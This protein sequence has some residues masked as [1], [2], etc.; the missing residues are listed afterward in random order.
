[1]NAAPA[2]VYGPWLEYLPPTLFGSILGISGLG[3]AWRHAEA[4]FGWSHLPGDVVLIVG[5]I[6]LAIVLPLYAAKFILLRKAVVGDIQHPVKGPFLA[7]MP[8]TILLQTSALAPFARETA[9]VLWI[10]GAF[11]S[12]GLNLYLFVGWYQRE[13]Q[14]QDFNAFWLIPGVGSFV[15]AITGAPLGFIEL[16]WFFFFGWA[17]VLGL[18]V[19]CAHVSLHRLAGPPRAIGADILGANCTA[20]ADEHDLSHANG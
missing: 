1:M 11:F 5:A 3:L 14:I 10:A 20:R 12:L 7:A 13:H 18:F 8:L 15:V 6:M 2:P 17:G 16:S 9:E 19:S 4:G